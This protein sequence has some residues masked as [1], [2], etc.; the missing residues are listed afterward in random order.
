MKNALTSYCYTS[1]YHSWTLLQCP[2]FI[3]FYV[4]ILS[5]I[6]YAR[7]CSKEFFFSKVKKVFFSYNS[8]LRHSWADFFIPWFWYNFTIWVFTIAKKMVFPYSKGWCET[9]LF[10]FT[11]LYLLFW[12]SG[13]LK[14]LIISNINS[15][16]IRFLWNPVIYHWKN[17]YYIYSI[18][19]LFVL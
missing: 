10:F 19:L 3:K 5:G 16:R 15:Q 13:I 17:F 12:C 7:F 2:I 14:T 9:S 6:M 8:Q 1:Y 18:Q 11:N 4:P